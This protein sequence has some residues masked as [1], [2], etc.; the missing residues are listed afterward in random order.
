MSTLSTVRSVAHQQLLDAVVQELPKATGQHE[1]CF[2]VAPVTHVGHQDLTL[3]PPVH[4]IV[5][6][7]GSPPVTLNSDI[8]V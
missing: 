7:L 6:A 2:L 1:R 8:S 5:N 3:E 4:P